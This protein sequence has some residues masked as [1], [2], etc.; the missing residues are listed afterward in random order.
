M[1]GIENF[2]NTITTGLYNPDCAFYVGAFM[3]SI[4]FLRIFIIIWGLSI[5]TNLLN[6]I[7]GY[8]Y[9]RVRFRLRRGYWKW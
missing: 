3:G 2:T 8:F 7:F 9:K 4:N 6:K 1:V 5:L